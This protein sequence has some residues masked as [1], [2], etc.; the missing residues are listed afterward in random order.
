LKFSEVFGIDPTGADW[1]VPLLSAD[2]PLFID[3]L[4]IAEDEQ[5][6]WQSAH[7]QLILFFNQVLTLIAKSGRIH[8]AGCRHRLRPGQYSPVCKCQPP[9]ADVD[10]HAPKGR[11]P[12][13]HP[14]GA[15]AF[16]SDPRCSSTAVACLSQQETEGVRIPPHREITVKMVLKITL[17]MLEDWDGTGE[18]TGSH[19]HP[20]D[21]RSVPMETLSRST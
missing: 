14:W 19:R 11:E 12:S 13:R 18:P 4:L 5:E 21:G 16:D 15:Q 20:S 8:A 1:F 2:T 7:K 6:Y 9:P 17:G 10:R 3:P